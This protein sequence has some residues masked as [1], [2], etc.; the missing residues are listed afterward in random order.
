MKRS[1]ALDLLQAGTGIALSTPYLLL[2]LTLNI[3]SHVPSLTTPC[4]PVLALSRL[5]L[6]HHLA[7]DSDLARDPG[8]GMGPAPGYGLPQYL[9]WKSGTW[10]YGAPS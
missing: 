7:V 5:C 1:P 10:P 4:N 8:P 2:V 3:H 9:A 6:G